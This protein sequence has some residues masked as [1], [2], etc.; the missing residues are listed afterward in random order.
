MTAGIR[1]WWTFSDSPGVC[2]RDARYT[3]DTRMIEPTTR[4]TPDERA[5]MRAEAIETA[6]RTGA[7]VAA[8]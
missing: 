1:N 8:T 6:R 3:V 2:L 5:A 7:A 4:W